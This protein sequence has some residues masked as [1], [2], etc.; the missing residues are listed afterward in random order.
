MLFDLWAWEE[1]L[2]PGHEDARAMP[3]RLGFGDLLLHLGATL[4]IRV[5]RSSE[6]KRVREIRDFITGWT[7]DG[8]LDAAEP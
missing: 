6:S 8:R 3:D 2:N 1:W 7:A 5:G 4:G